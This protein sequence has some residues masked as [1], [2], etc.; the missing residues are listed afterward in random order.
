MMRLLAPFLGGFLFA[1]GL[2]I[3]GMT[4]ANK[5]LGFLN[6]AGDWDPSLAFVMVGAIGI[7][8]GLYRLILRR[9]SPLFDVAF[10]VPNRREINPALIGGAATFGVGWGLGGIC[11][12]PGLVSLASLG[13]PTI[14]FMATMVVG[15][16]LQ[17]VTSSS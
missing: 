8:V 16:I 15:M 1:I 11:P 14:V 4:D 7:H 10:K 3:S 17:K 2:G 9:K 6:L 12:G 5:V 13:L